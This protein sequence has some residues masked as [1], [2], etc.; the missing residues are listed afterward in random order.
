MPPGPEMLYATTSAASPNQILAMSIDP[1]T[2]EL[3]NAT[4][5]SGPANRL[6]LTAVHG[7]YLYAS[8]TSGAQ[9]FR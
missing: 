5:I 9:V 7:Q 3:G 6:G 4:S 1:A 2:G 8:D